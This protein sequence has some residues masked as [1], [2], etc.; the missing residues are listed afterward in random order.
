MAKHNWPADDV[1]IEGVVAAGGPQQWANANGVAP[2]SVR[3][4]LNRQGIFETIRTRLDLSAV[5]GEARDIGAQV[6]RAKTGEQKASTTIKG[7]AATIVT[8]PAPKIGDP[9]EWIAESGL[10]PEEWEAYN[11]KLNTWDAMTS[12]KATG[13][14]QIVK[15]FQVTASAKR[16]VKLDWLFPAADVKQRRAPQPKIEKGEPQRVVLFPDQHA[17]YN[18]ERLHYLAMC[19]LVDWAPH[20][21]VN[22]GDVCDYPSISK[23]KDNPAYFAAAQVCAQAGF[24][25]L[26]DQRTAAPD[27]VMDMLLGNHDARPETELL[28]R[29]ER[30][31]DF[32]PATWPGEDAPPRPW[33]PRHVLNLDRLHVNFTGPELDGDSYFQGVLAL[34]PDIAAVHGFITGSNSASGTVE[35]LGQS[36]FF[37]HSHRQK[38]H[39][40]TKYKGKEPVAEWVGVECGTMRGIKGGGGFSFNPQWQQG[41]VTASI[42]PDGEFTYD[43]ARF[44]GTTLTWREK[45]YR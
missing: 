2:S 43:V 14:N 11:I 24:E 26:H 9:A 32:R 16:K 25:I 36:V 3:H 40:V 1:L 12:D 22:L 10:D 5:I 28:A 41:Y 29:A 35:R 30:M 27:A 4:R 21:I 45:R 39:H 8:R 17:P 23:Y 19:H 31:W 37:G 42:W 7:D 18:D 20:R 6:K 34:A 44:N 38:I 13:D 15:M 33:S